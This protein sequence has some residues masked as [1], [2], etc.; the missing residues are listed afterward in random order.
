MAAYDKRAKAVDGPGPSRAERKK[1][2]S[3]EA[4]TA[5]EKTKSKP[6][7]PKY[8]GASSSRKT[9]STPRKPKPIPR[10]SNIKYNA[11]GRRIK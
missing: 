1:S 3:A 7:K 11:R 2:M 6:T 10:K 5:F 4:M 9:G 8:K